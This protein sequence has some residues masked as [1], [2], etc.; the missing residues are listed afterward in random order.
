MEIYVLNWIL[1]LIC[2]IAVKK[3]KK[4]FRESNF[5]VKKNPNLF[6]YI[7]K[8]FTESTGVESEN[9]GAK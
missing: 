2:L 5:L 3:R 4:S 7:Y 9:I 6:G 8:Y 1:M